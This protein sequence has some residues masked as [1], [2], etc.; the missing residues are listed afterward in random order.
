M[1][2]V[3]VTCSASLAWAAVPDSETGAFTGCVDNRSKV[4]RVIDGEAGEICKKTETAISWSQVGPAGP[5][6]ALGPVGPAGPQG[7]QGASGVPGPQGAMGERGLTGL[8]GDRGFTGFTG[9]QGPDGLP[10]ATGP[11]GPQGPAGFTRVLASE[12]PSQQLTDFAWTPLAQLTIPA[13]VS[14]LQADVGITNIG[15][16]KHNVACRLFPHGTSATVA[17]DS[18]TGHADVQTLSFTRVIHVTSPTVVDFQ[19]AGDS[20]VT[21][22]SGLWVSRP[23][24][25]VLPVH[26]FG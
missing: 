10:G 16:A 6:G 25:V 8:Q 9:S 14:V 18:G 23:Y 5:D 19:C 1:G 2:T 17:L 26:Q 4:L 20:S 12:G 11:Q 3:V 22:A 15:D 24:L 7:F 13:G 21:S